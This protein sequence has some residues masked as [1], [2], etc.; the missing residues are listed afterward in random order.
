MWYTCVDWSNWALVIVAGITGWVVWQ[1]TI[2]TR[3][4]V[5]VNLRPKLSIPAIALYIEG[6]GGSDPQVLD[7]KRWSIE[8]MIANV[9][10]GKARIVES[11]LTLEPS[12]GIGDS[13]KGLLAVFPRYDDSQ[14]SFGNIAIMPGERHTVKVPLTD[15]QISTLKSYEQNQQGGANMSTTQVVCF[16]FIRYLD[17]LESARRM[18]FCF[19]YDITK[20]AFS[21]YKHPVYDYSD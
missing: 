17:D 19:R 12:L 21:R 18:G 7:K 4:S 8:C 9:G 3:R 6:A 5:L 10:G 13:P 1:Q 20:M 16:G 2:A 15:R 14:G 11:N